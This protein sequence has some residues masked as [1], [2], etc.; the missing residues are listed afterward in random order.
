MAQRMQRRMVALNALLKR[1]GLVRQGLAALHQR[2]DQ[3]LILI[4]IRQQ[5]LL[6]Q[7]L[8]QVSNDDI[9][10][11]ESRQQHAG[12]TGDPV[13]CPT[14]HIC[15]GRAGLATLE[16]VQRLRRM[17]AVG[18]RACIRASSAMAAS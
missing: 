2:V 18:V 13:Q 9:Q 15:Q 6:G 14:G 17:P 8:G 3:G 1:L 7:A 11:A 16:Q 10:L 4:R 12:D 5:A